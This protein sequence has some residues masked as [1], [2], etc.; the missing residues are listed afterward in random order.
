MNTISQYLAE[1]FSIIP[2]ID[3]IPV[4]GWKKYQ[5]EKITE[6]EFLKVTPADYGMVMGAVSGNCEAIDIDVKHWAGIDARYFA[7]IKQLYPDLFPKLRIHKTPS[8]GYHIIYRCAQPIGEGNLKLAVRPGAKEAGI[9]TRGEGGYICVPPTPGYIVTQDVPVPVI[10]RSER[11]SLIQLAKL[12]DSRTKAP[13][14]PKLPISF[15]STYDESPFDHFN[16]SDEGAMILQKHGWTIAHDSTQFIQFIRPGKDKGLGA[17]YIKEKNCY[18]IFTTSSS[19]EGDKNYSPVQV[20]AHLE[21]QGDFK[22]VYRYLVESGFGRVKPDVEARNMH[23]YVANGSELPA[24]FSGEAKSEFEYQKKAHK[25]KYPHG[26]FWDGDYEISRQR[27]YDVAEEMGL[28]VFK[29]DIPCKIIGNKVRVLTPREF[30]DDI[31]SYIQEED[32][33][34]YVDICNSYEEFLQKAGN[35]T[36]Q[37]IRKLDKSEFLTSTLET[38]YKYFANFYIEITK[39][40]ITQKDYSLLEKLIWERDICERNYVTVSTDQIKGSLYYSFLDLAI[41]VEKHDYH[42]EKCI[43]FLCHDYKDETTG[44]IIV[45][46]E[47]VPDPRD[48]GGAGKNVFASLM[49]GSTTVCEVPGSMVK[50]DSTF[51]QSWNNE[52]IFIV[53]DALKSFDFGFVKNLS[54]NAGKVKKLYKDEEEIAVS[55]M[56]KIVVLT[57]YSFEIIDGGI[58]RRIIPIEFSDFF[59]KSGGIDTHFGMHFPRGWDEDQWACYDNYIIHC[60]QSYLKEPKLKNN[61][62]SEGGWLK[63]FDQTYGVLTRQF[64]D[65]NFENWCNAGFIV[66]ENF[67]IA[68]DNFCKENNINPKFQLASQRMNMGLNEYSINHGYEFNGK[69]QKKN[70]GINQKAKLFTKIGH[71]DVVKEEQIQ[72]DIPF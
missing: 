57:N 48:G 55:E 61:S 41:G 6:M 32:P 53:S 66:I 50:T 11:D 39:D 35:F 21:Y 14:K 12:Y 43:G 28:R 20:L 22:R 7:E 38:S 8:G 58:K 64:I 19:L 51:L 54:T 33:E 62:L 47:E 68:Y 70:N 44:Y 31:K 13:I 5:T 65:E 25:N 63:Q 16:R 24:N 17:S 23:K 4:R 2:V 34:V 67:N 9:E 10:T 49:K 26:I 56:P 15:E 29:K 60:I 71:I 18:H 46:T 27:L 42:L 1:N 59:T 36:I 72:S 3:K 52:R 37:R 30:F 40:K 45:L 69:G